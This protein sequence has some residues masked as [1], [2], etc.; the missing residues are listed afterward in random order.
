MNIT[1]PV[2]TF[3]KRIIV[4]Q[5][6][7]SVPIVVDKGTPLYA[8]LF[9]R[10]RGN[11]EVTTALMSELPQT[12][13]FSLIDFPHASSPATCLR[14]GDYLNRHHRRLLNDYIRKREAAG[15]SNVA[16]IQEFCDA[17]GI[18]LDVDITFD[19]IIRDYRR[20]KRKNFQDKKDDFF[21]I[22]SAKNGR[23]KC[24]NQDAQ[25]PDFS[26]YSDAEL[27]A[28]IE[29]YYTENMP[30]FLRMRDKAE[31][32]LMKC[33]L[34]AF[35]YRYCAHRSV[36]EVCKKLNIPKKQYYKVSRYAAAFQNHLISLP[37]LE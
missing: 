17:H 27:D 16:A 9:L 19:A 4:K 36:A 29:K 1:I 8:N 7:L 28:Y 31:L 33:K 26:L 35:I 22:K 13:H 20:K 3:S 14:I 5:Y 34:I 2:S 11:V 21:V 37:P 12:L 25:K 24:H 32:K 23:S 30:I 10:S 15:V 18:L 6:G